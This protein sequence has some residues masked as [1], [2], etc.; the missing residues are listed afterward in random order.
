[1]TEYWEQWPYCFTKIKKTGYKDFLSIHPGELL[2]MWE[3]TNKST[4]NETQK[5][6]AFDFLRLGYPKIWAYLVDQGYFDLAGKDTGDNSWSRS[7]FSHARKK[8]A[9]KEK[10]KTFRKAKLTQLHVLCSV[11][12]GKEIMQQVITSKT[13][14]FELYKEACELT[15]M[16]W[17]LWGD[18]CFYLYNEME[19]KWDIC[20]RDRRIL[21]TSFKKLKK[22][23]KSK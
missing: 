9:L 18:D 6:L 5:V 1:M 11:Q 7:G 22:K 23:V 3:K 19:D 12:M 10:G 8:N 16:K 14:F 4:K 15:D 17:I 13:N 20:S 21:K 2:S